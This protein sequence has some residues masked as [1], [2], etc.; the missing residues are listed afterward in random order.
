MPIIRRSSSTPALA[1]I[2]LLLTA[3]GLPL[4]ARA[5]ASSEADH[6]GDLPVVLSAT[7]LAQVQSDAPGAVSIID[8]AM[9]SASGARNIHELFRL[10]PGFQ[11]GM[12]TGNKPLVG[13]HGLSDE[14]PRRMLLQVDG[15]SVYSPYFT[16]GVEWNQIGV[17]IDDIERIEVFRGSN[18]ATYGSNAFLGVANIITRA[19]AETLGTRVR[20]R[21]GDGGVNDIGLRVGRQ[22]GDVAMRLSV[23]RNFDHGFAGLN[24]WR[25]TELA[26]LHSRWTADSDNSVEFQAGWTRSELGTGK[27]GNLT[28]PE[29][30][31]QV[32][33]SFGLIHWH[34]ASAPGEELSVSYYHQE[35]SGRDNYNLLI[36]VTSR[37]SGL[38]FAL[39]LPLRFDYDFHVIRDDLEIQRITTL[40]PSLRAV[41]GAGM[42]VDRITAPQRFN[43]TDSVRNAVNHAFGTL[44]WHANP[45]WLFNVGAMI[46]NNSL[47]G[48]TL[49]PRASANYHITDSQTWRVSVNRSHRNPIAFEQKSSMIFST[50]APVRTPVGTF[51][52]GTPISQTFRPSP[53]VQA[54]RITTYE[55]GYRAELRPLHASLDARIFLE[56]AR[57]LIEMNL[58]DSTI[59]LLRRSNNRYF[60]NS[61]EA[62][63]RGLEIAAT[64]R[65][66]TD[67]WLQLN[68]T[69]LRIDGPSL[70]ATAAASRPSGW[71][72]YTAPRHSTTVFGAWQFAPRWQL[73]VARHWI[74]SMSWYQDADHK[75]PMYRQLDVRLAHRLPPALARG[76]LAITASNIDGPEET[77]APGTSVWGS[78]IFG[79]LSL[80][81]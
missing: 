80:E 48:R 38:P 6:L 56:Q 45:R 71:V 41:V 8:R 62:D 16:A 57:E 65:P 34:H 28:D 37:Q 63:I 79:S 2:P 76:E 54:E 53:Q 19:P 67:T 14:A 44:E 30:S 51:P 46:E 35:E 1:C 68:H 59:G 33:T 49:A 17:D 10:V 64:W 40:A 21:A 23:A 12:H 42:R 69:E 18:S 58:E 55:L 61:G 81:L 52:A 72:E 5:D 32:S 50:A 3:V 39:Q 27:E 31:S 29:R 78:R 60:A 77:Y 22:L 24:D 9:I 25:K 36:P 70:S 13:Y 20:Y 15:R 7:R 26:T 11:V 47:T 66:G 4:P 43:T 73:S 74:G 75:V